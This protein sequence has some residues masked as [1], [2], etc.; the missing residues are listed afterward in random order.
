M[1]PKDSNNSVNDS[2][3]TVLKDLLLE[4]TPSACNYPSTIPLMN[5]KEKLKCRQ[6]KAVLQYYIP[7]RHKYPEKYAHHLL[8]M[9]YPFRNEE[10]LKSSNLGTF[11]EKL[12]DPGI[13]DI[14]NRNK[15]IF[16]PYG[17]INGIYM[18]AKPPCSI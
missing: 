1:L 5:S 9:F 16:E 6:V 18:V 8:F 17:Y 14:V 13:L 12:Q 4:S 11:S 2:Q 10:H 3:P 15:Q 7:N